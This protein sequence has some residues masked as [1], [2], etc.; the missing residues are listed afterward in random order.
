MPIDQHQ[1]S[2]SP[3]PLT[4]LL[5]SLSPRVLLE[6]IK[7]DE[8]LLRSVLQG[9][10][11]RE[12]SLRKPVVRQRLERALQL[13]PALAS[14][15]LQSWMTQHAPLMRRLNDP[16]IPL[17]LVALH[18]LFKE[19]GSETLEYGLLHATRKDAAGWAARMAEIRCFT[20]PAGPHVTLFAKQEKEPARREK[21]TG[22]ERRVVELE[23][24][25][26]TLRHELEEVSRRLA[27]AEEREAALRKQLADSEG[28]LEREQRRAKKAEEETAGLRK[29]Q[30]KPVPAPAAPAKPA[31]GK[32]APAKPAPAPPNPPTDSIA[33]ISSAIAALQQSLELLTAN[34]PEQT[35][36]AAKKA[37]KPVVPV[38]EAM[39]MRSAGMSISLPRTHGKLS[40]TL[41]QI[42]TAL[43]HN[44]VTLINNVRDGL[45]RLAT[46][47]EKEREALRALLGAGIPKTVLTGP[48]RPAVVDGSN[49]ANMSPQRKGRLI[50]LEQVRRAAWDEGYFPVIIIIDASLP[51]QIDAPEALFAMVERGEVEMVPPG[52]SADERL[53]AA[54]LELHAVV[55][56]NDRLTDWPA[57]KE[58]EKRH[59]EFDNNIIRLGN[60]HRSWLPW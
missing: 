50:Y 52:T 18:G 51:Y 34:P 16:T 32:P 42:I 43:I 39:E 22:L 13:Q 35:A 15:L 19:V 28:R 7:H 26:D 58:L 48:L 4:Q 33:A 27:Q 2:P 5:S 29:Q 36:R 57:A 23:Q 9:F 41:A 14:E 49:I 12:L 1:S 54:A 10:T 40:H 11:V 55:I 53:I 6:F 30:R 20:P 21:T 60:F 44:D 47:K 37:A 8:A 17:T 25:R 3:E 59:A 45:A 24:L 31:P 38:S 56:T 46:N